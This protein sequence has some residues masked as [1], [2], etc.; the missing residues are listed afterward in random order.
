MPDETRIDVVTALALEENRLR[1]GRGGG[2]RLLRGVGRL[3]REMTVEQA[4]AELST[5][6]ASS[7][8]QAPKLY[9]E[10]VSLRIMP[11]RESV[12]QDV[13]AVAIVLLGA[14][15]SILLI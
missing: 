13:R 12:V 14:V 8:A 9:G 7:R 3:Q 4:R 5:R 2:R 10:D 6:L 11:L 15:A 1:H